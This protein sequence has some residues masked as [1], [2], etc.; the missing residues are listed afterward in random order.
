MMTL[1]QFLSVWEGIF[2]LAG[3]LVIGVGVHW[4]GTWALWRWSAREMARIPTRWL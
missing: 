3:L 2:L 1:E 4:L